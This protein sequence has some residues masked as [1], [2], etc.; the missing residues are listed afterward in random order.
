MQPPSSSSRALE[1]AATEYHYQLDGRTIS[2]LLERRGLDEDSVVGFHLGSVAKPLPGHEAYRGRLAIPYLTKTGVAAMKFRCIEDHEC[3]DLQHGKYMWPQGQRSHLYNVL[4]TFKS[5]DV[6][7]V[8]EGELDTITVSSMVGIPA[9]GVAGVSHW[10]PFY[11]RILDGYS[12]VLVI[13]DNDEREG[14]DD[15][16][17]MDLARRILDELPQAEIVALPGGQDAN[18][19]VREQGPAALRTLCRFDTIETP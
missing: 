5:S 10:K 2:Y 8:C 9:V 19:Y 3:R 18:S 12:R 7:A 15:N 4:D 13:A 16:P 6:M 14:R 1:Q 11:R 17:G